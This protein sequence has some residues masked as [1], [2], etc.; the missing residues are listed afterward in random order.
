MT[1]SSTALPLDALSQKR[2]C[3]RALIKLA[4]QQH[5][6]ILS[7]DLG[8]LMEVLATKQR[9]MGRMEEVQR[10]LVS[11]REGPQSWRDRLDSEVEGQCQGVLEET[12]QLLADLLG[13]EKQCEQKLICLRE[14]AVE[15]LRQTDAGRQLNRAYLREM[16]PS[17]NRL[18]D[19]ETE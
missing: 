11:F 15:Q 8:A 12:E 1:P 4:N 2:D 19:L 9:V 6:L 14:E 18:V 17:T 7:G 3:C 16:A 5:A 10:R 13:I